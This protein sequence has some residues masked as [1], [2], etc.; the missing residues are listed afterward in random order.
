MLRGNGKI[1]RVTAFS[2]STE[3]LY[4]IET[5][6]EHISMSLSMKPVDIK[7]LNYYKDNDT[8]LDGSQL[9]DTVRIQPITDK[10]LKDAHFEERSQQIGDFNAANRWKKRGMAMVPLRWPAGWRAMYNCL[11]TIFH[12][13][14]TV[15]VSH[16]G[17]EI[18]QG[19]NT[20]VLLL[21]FN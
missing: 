13:G 12:T 10:L 6:M 19:I 2:G 20:K 1:G 8:T 3:G 7:Q 16:G 18:G 14:G 4:F 21:H 15:A 9:L 17:I 5:I 11:V